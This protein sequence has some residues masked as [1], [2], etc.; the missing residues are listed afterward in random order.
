MFGFTELADLVLKEN[1]L[2]SKQSPDACYITCRA[3]G[4]SFIGVSA[5]PPYCI[6]WFPYF[7]LP[8]RKHSFSF[9]WNTSFQSNLILIRSSF[10]WQCQLA[11]ASELHVCVFPSL[12]QMANKHWSSRLK[13]NSIFKIFTTGFLRNHMHTQISAKHNEKVK[14][15]RFFKLWNCHGYISAMIEIMHII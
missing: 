10:C 6:Q 4:D 14:V 12:S 15:R 8:C 1:T 7:L 3:K 13:T 2:C 11:S 5:S 9:S